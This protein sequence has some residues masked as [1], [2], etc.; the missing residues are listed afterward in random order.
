MKKLLLSLIATFVASVSFAQTELLTNGSFEEWTDDYPTAWKSASTASSSA[1]VAKST[2]ARTGTYAVEIKGIAS[3]NKRLASE[4]ITLKPGTYTFSIWMKSAGDASVSKIG[5]TPVTDGTVGSYVYPKNEEDKEIELNLTS[6]YAQYS[7]TFTLE[8]K[9]T[10]CLVAMNNKKSNAVSI[11]ADDA[12]LTTTDGGIDE[13]GDEPSTP[14]GAITVAEALAKTSGTATVAATTY[15]VCNNGFVIGDATGFMYVYKKGVDVAVGDEVTI[16]DGALSQYGGFTQFNNP[17]TIEKGESKTVTYPTAEELDGAAL[18]AWFESP[19]IKYVKV[20]GTLTISGNY[21]NLN[22]EGTEKAIGSLVSPVASVLASD[23]TNNSKVTVV[24]F[25]MYTSGGKY[26]NIVATSVT[27][28]E[29]GETKDITNTPETA[30]TTSEAKAIVDEGLGLEQAVYVKGTVVGENLS[31]ATDFGNANYYITDGSYQLYVYRGNYV[32]NT[33]FTSED[34]LKEGDEVII[35][36]KL[37]NYAKTDSE[38]G[39]VTNIPEF[40]QGNYIYSLNG[41]TNSIVNVNVN[42]NAKTIYDLSGRR[43]EKAVKG[44]YIVNGKKVIF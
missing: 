27:I 9:T 3:S 13:S 34:Q 2:D 4:E 12:S 16:T 8:A 7:M 38:T 41:V 24:G 23:V 26:V 25:A 37:Q 32:E 35:Y 15:A 14:E 42:A 22:V 21:Y 20:K 10:V 31:I 44:I 11:I 36:G 6:E 5:Y 18:D 40:T 33:K 17:S 28:D 29:A 1:T 30:Y 39:V 43:V 19:A